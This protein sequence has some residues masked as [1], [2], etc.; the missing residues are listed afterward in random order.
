MIPLD[1]VLSF[2]ARQHFHNLID[3]KVNAALFAHAIDARKKF[4][5][6]QSSVIGLAR[7]KAIVAAATIALAK[8]LAEV[9]QQ[10]DA[11]ALAALRKI[12][13]LPELGRGD[14]SLLLVGHLVNEPRV[15]DCIP[16]A[17]KQKAFA[18]QPIA[19]GAA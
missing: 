19:T 17:E 4:L 8:V 11:T 3:A 12:D 13:H 15:F 16:G 9:T 5:P 6:G 2:G 14:L 7:G 1:N 10:N 18:W